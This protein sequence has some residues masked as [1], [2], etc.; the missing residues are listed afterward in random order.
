M[1][2]KRWSLVLAGLLAVAPVFAA[3]SQEGAAATD[4]RLTISW[5]GPNNR[6]VLLPPDS[7]TELFLEEYFDVELEP[8]T[9]VDLYQSDQIGRAHV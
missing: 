9:D 2:H 3:P 1:A 6:G 4:E 5:M 7:P 8:W